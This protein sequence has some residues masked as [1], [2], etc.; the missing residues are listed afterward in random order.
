M[1]TKI[2]KSINVSLIECATKIIKKKKSTVDRTKKEYVEKNTQFFSF[3]ALICVTRPMAQV[4]LVRCVSI[5]YIY[6]YVRRSKYIVECTWCRGL[7]LF[8]EICRIIAFVGCQ[9]GFPFTYIVYQ[10][11]VCRARVLKVATNSPQYM[12]LYKS[13]M[14]EAWCDRT[15]YISWILNSK[16]TNARI[17]CMHIRYVVPLVSEALD[18]L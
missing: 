10:N 6:I 15:T 5:Y 18:Q 8:I 14:C 17:H 13:K 7:Y 1:F 16:M 4:E 2:S 12:A 9:R 11:H 3:F